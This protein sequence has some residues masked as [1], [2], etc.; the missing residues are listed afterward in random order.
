MVDE[1][2]DV[3]SDTSRVLSSIGAALLILVCTAIGIAFIRITL[4]QKNYEQ[5]AEG[6]G[7]IVSYIEKYSAPGDSILAPPY[8]AFIS[9]RLLYE[10]Y[11]ELFIWTIKYY[12]ETI[13][14]RRPGEGVR[15]AESIA[16]ALARQQIPIVVLDLKQTGRIPPIRNALERFYTPLL[17][18]PIQTLNT[19]L[20][21]YIPQP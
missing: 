4:V 6:V 18:K 14:E 8:Y 11:S 16:M 20:Q 12:N 5:D 2:I 7:H 17:E 21:I 15:K 10:E 1:K 13:V 19:P 3:A 9:Q